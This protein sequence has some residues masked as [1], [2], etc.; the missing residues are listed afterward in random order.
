MLK[1]WDLWGPLLVCMTLSIMLSISAPEDQKVTALSRPCSCRAISFNGAIFLYPRHWCSLVCLCSC[2][3]G[4]LLSRSTRS[5]WGAQFLSFSL[6]AYWVI[7]FSPSMVISIC[8]S[9]LIKNSGSTTNLFFFFFFSGLCLVPRLQVPI[10]FDFTAQIWC[11][12][13]GI[14]LVDEGF[15]RVH[16]PS[17]FTRKKSSRSLSRIF[18]LYLHYMDGNYQLMKGAHTPNSKHSWSHHMVNLFIEKA[19]CEECQ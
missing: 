15:S 18:F 4:P 1:E 2:G 6:Y 11:S 19:T 16:E 10:F 9:S 13:R 8:I 5:S 14:R 3:S 12:C 17:H 7:A